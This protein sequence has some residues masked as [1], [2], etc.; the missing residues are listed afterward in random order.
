MTRSNDCVLTEQLFHEVH[1]LWTVL[2]SYFRKGFKYSATMRVSCYCLND[3][4]AEM[5]PGNNGCNV[6][7]TGAQSQ[8][9]GGD[10]SS[11]TA[12]YNGLRESEFILY[13]IVFAC[14]PLC[15]V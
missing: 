6:N 12:L 14:L 5:S 2:L 10:N 15:Q 11:Y 3:L 1:F 8:L 7:C 4:N 9:C 13:S